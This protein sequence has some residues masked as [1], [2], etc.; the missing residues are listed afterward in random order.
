MELDPERCYRAVV[1][2]DRRFDGRFFTAVLTTGVYCRPVCPARRPARENVRF[3]ACA[4]AAENAGFRPC[5]RCRP[6]TAPGSAAWRG[7]PATVS[8]ALRLIEDGVLDRDGVEGLAARLGVTD[9]W[10]RQLFESQLGASP[11]AVARTRRIHFARRLLDESAMPVED[12]AQAAGF[13]SA[14]R[15]RDAIQATFRRSPAALRGRRAARGAAAASAGDHP[16]PTAASLKVTARAP[17]DPAPLFAFLAARAVPGVEAVERGAYRRSAILDGETGVVEVRPID[18]ANA[19][20]VRWSGASAR[21]L[22]DLATRVTRLFDLD[23][24]VAAIGAVLGRD[25]RLARQWPAHGVR[26]PGAWDPF[27][28][29]MRALLGQQVSVAAAR[30]L[31]G[32][33]V[34]RCGTPLDRPPEGGPTHLFPAAGAVAS[35]DLTRLGITGARE[36]AVRGFAE[37]VASGA[38]DLVAPRSLDDT[39]AR[40]T[41]LPGVGAWTAQYIAMR[42]LGETDAFPAGDL[43]VRKALAR[44]GRM[45]SERETIARAERWRPW[46]AYAT[47]ALWTGAPAASRPRANPRSTDPRRKP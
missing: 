31:A 1:A 35:A 28:L 32:R 10:L 41:R 18:G 21:G 13:G 39:V 27:E 42:A 30:T 47:L 16:P 20:A 5:L 11:L 26:V 33:L 17:F 36:H 34:A 14:R 9:R 15:L 37:A 7:T 40:L 6:E 12:V 43:G 2:R 46:R 44:G 19:L 22:L 8:R 24:D 29:A 4:A 23:A 38:L 3:Y 45:P 25:P